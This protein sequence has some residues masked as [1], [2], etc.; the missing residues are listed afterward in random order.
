[1]KFGA[2]FH[3]DQVNTT[4]IAQFNGSF[5]FTGSQTGSDFADFLLGVPSQYNQSQ[6]APF[7]WTQ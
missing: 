5:L 3:Y 7:L 6:L 4:A 1:M 2:E